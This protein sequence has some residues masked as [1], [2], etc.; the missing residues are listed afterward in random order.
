MRRAEDLNAKEIRVTDNL[1]E[2]GW[3][4]WSAD[5]RKIIYTTWDRNAEPGTYHVWTTAIDQDTGVIGKAEE[6]HFPPTVHSPQIAVFSPDG[7]EIALE[8][9]SAPGQRI[10][11]AA[12][13]DGKK[14]EKIAAY[15][16]ETYGGV[17]WTPDGKTLLFAGLDGQRMQ[18]FSIPRSGGTPRRLTDGKGNLIG[19]SGFPGWKVDRLSRVDTVQTL[20]RRPY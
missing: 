20:L 13:A 1:W 17:D 19:P 2:T 9:A 8:D 10:L 4:Y 5:G 16:S 11:W 14:V 6:I 15:E 3:V 12:S 7:K 18:I